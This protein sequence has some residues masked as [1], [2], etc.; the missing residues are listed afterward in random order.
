MQWTQHRREA[1]YRNC[2]N[3]DALFWNVMAFRVQRHRTPRYATQCSE[4]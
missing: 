4:V 3:V 2:G 1:H